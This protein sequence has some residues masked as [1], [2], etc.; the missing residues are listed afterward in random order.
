[1]LGCKNNQHIIKVVLTREVRMPT[2]DE[3]NSC[4]VPFLALRR[5]EAA[6]VDAGSAR[7]AE[8]EGEL[9]IR[10]AAIGILQS[11][12][13][14]AMEE[15]RRL[16]AQLDEQRRISKRLAGDNERLREQVAMMA[17]V[18]GPA[19]CL[20]SAVD[21][22]QAAIDREVA[23]VGGMAASMERACNDAV[24]SAIRAKAG[25]R[26][27]CVEVLG[28]KWD[29]AAEK[30]TEP[31]TAAKASPAPSAQKIDFASHE[32]TSQASRRISEGR[33]EEIATHAMH[34]VLGTRPAHDINPHTRSCVR[35]GC[36]VENIALGGAGAERCY[37]TDF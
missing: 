19:A 20:G 13:A 24:I 16:I 6:E 22:W 10:E 37:L 3:M 27:E 29:D 23:S 30:A 25:A 4:G 21:A 1:M 36:S 12:L 34:A 8:L 15:H 31:H 18:E 14:W 26:M 28:V 32:P 7:V 11:E 2:R 17:D 33:R 35:C 9:E 5:P